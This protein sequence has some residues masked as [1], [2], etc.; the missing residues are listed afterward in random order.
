MAQTRL[1]CVHFLPCSKQKIK[2]FH[3]DRLNEKQM[4]KYTAQHKM[5]RVICDDEKFK[6]K[7]KKNNRKIITTTE[8][9]KGIKK[10]KC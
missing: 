2:Q 5:R 4:K 8:E 7:K 10:N 1:I 3:F 6:T 9:I